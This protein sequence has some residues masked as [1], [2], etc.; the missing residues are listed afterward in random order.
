MIPRSTLNPHL[1][2]IILPGWGDLN[3]YLTTRILIPTGGVGFKNLPD[4]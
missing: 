2:V 3:S 4:W 1:R